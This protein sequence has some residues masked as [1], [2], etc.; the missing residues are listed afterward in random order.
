MLKNSKGGDRLN[1]NKAV[2]LYH[3]YGHGLDDAHHKSMED[4]LVKSNTLRANVITTNYNTDE[5]F[6]RRGTRKRKK[7]RP[8]WDQQEAKA[9][10]STP[11][12]SESDVEEND[13]DEVIEPDEIET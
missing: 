1:L 4:K 6:R 5:Q 10:R 12:E 7:A 3:L 9:T 11:S 13:L 8:F 2:H